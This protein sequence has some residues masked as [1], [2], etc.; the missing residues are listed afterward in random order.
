MTDITTDLITEPR[1]L[2]L[3]TA[4]WQ[5]E[6]QLTAELVVDEARDPSSPLHARFEWDDQ[7]AAHEH[8]LA[9][10]R[11]IIRIV[12]DVVADSKV[13]AFVHVPSSGGYQPIRQ[14]LN[15]ADWTREL[16]ADFRRDAERFRARWATHRQ[17]AS[18]YHDFVIAE[19]QTLEQAG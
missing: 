11:Q 5:R 8:R 10:A 12:A 14:V 7:K 18:A 6:G 4:I 2:E 17:A 13:R 15:H 16:L 9:Q 3:L 1:T 19:A